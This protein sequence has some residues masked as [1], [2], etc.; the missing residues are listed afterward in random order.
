ME[1]PAPT[2]ATLGEDQCCDLVLQALKVP[3]TEIADSNAFAAQHGAATEVMSNA[4][5]S[6]GSQDM[7]M[8]QSQ[9][10]IEWVMTEEGEGS[11]KHES[12]E[13][14]LFNRFPAEGLEEATLSELERHALNYLKSQRLVTFNKATKRCMKVE[15][16]TMERD[17]T[18]EMMVRFVRGSLEALSK[19]EQ[20]DV[21]KR[22]LV[23]KRTRKLIKVVRGPAYAETR[24]PTVPFLTKDM[25]AKGNWDQVNFKPLKLD[26]ISAHP[27]AGHLHPLMQYK[28][29]VRRIFISLGFQEMPTS[30]FVESSL[31]NFDALYQ[32]QAHPCR[33]MQDTFFMKDPALM[34]TMPAGGL[35]EKIKQM[36][37]QGGNG[38][39]GWR[40]HWKEE[41]RKNI[42]RT[43]TTAISARM[44]AQLG[45]NYPAKFFSI[46]RVFRNETL[47]ATHLAEF[48]QIEGMVIGKG[49]TLTHLMGTIRQFF[50]KIG[51]HD[52]S[53]QPTY[54]PYTEPSMEISAFH[55]GLNRRVEIGNSGIFRPEMLT[56][57]GLPNDVQ[58][59]A[60]GFSLERPTMI[61]YGISN[62][63]EMFGPRMDLDLIENH[64]LRLLGVHTN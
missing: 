17:T 37:E 13:F 56:Q 24:K 27:P 38:S 34:V 42:M 51:M 36:H 14:S 39:I 47:D 6:L 55:P 52:I 54:N 22:K 9:A 5:K 23:E 1:T 21:Q 43:H 10:V 26:A 15:G 46:D 19:D 50:E 60:W 28:S 31:W 30:R 25:L 41:G 33:D 29:M 63:R 2:P 40:Y 7:V 44:L 35:V 20:K 48:H 64:P 32:P 45:Q 11:F 53:F 12:A 58:V 59:L 57:L 61:L 49:L 4:I 62:I 8:T 18:H 16:A 3:G